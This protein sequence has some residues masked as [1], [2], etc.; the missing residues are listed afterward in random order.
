MFVESSLHV[1]VCGILASGASP[2]DEAR[3]LCRLPGGKCWCLPTDM[4][5]WVFA[6]FG[7]ELCHG[8]LEAARG[9]K[10]LGCLSAGGW[11]CVPISFIVWPEATY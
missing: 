2:V 3:G 4:L 7:A 6:F 10:S 11:G 9:R 8:D 1:P 5:S